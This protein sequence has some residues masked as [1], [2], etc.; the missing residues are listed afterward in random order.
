MDN[1]FNPSFG[2][3]QIKNIPV[4]FIGTFGTIISLV[5]TCSAYCKKV[6]LNLTGIY[7]K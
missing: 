7:G 3:V 4:T 5:I 1:H 6:A 2:I